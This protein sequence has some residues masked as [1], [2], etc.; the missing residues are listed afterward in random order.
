MSKTKF[1]QVE[2]KNAL[3]EMLQEGKRFEKIYLVSTA[4]KDPKTKEIVRLASSMQTNIEKVTRRTLQ[5]RSKVS[6][7]ESVIGLL[8]VQNQYT[9]D[10][11]ME[12]TYESGR[13]P[14]FLIFGDI[15]Y[16]HNVGAIFRTA[17]A[18]GVNGIVTPVEKKNFLTD[19]IV[20]LSMGTALRIPIVEIGLFAAIKEFQKNGINIV[21]LDMDGESIYQSNLTGPMA[22]VL[23][24]EDTGVSAKLLERADNSVSIPMRPGLG[25]LNVSVSA[26]VTMYEKIRQDWA[27]KI[28]KDINGL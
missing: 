25:S 13:E 21:A 12:E 4:Y 19:E 8:E 10:G 6:S 7:H 15:K 2:N 28:G 18:A 3:L 11:L 26:A 9:L 5:R 16:P 24:S 23:G 27:S 14:F 20:R 22:I 1:I 17:Y